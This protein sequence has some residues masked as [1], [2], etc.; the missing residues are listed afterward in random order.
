MT[1]KM[2]IPIMVAAGSDDPNFV[3]AVYALNET[4]LFESPANL[5]SCPPHRNVLLILEPCC[6]AH[7]PR[8]QGP[9]STAE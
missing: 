2:H 7:I 1:W 5:A 6:D 4:V 9:E 3:R 8:S